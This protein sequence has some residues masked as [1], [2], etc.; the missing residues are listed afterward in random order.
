MATYFKRNTK[1]ELN[2]SISFFEVNIVVRSSHTNKSIKEFSF[3]GTLTVE[4]YTC[5]DTVNKDVLF[6]VVHAVSS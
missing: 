1:N 4:K 3:M 2:N 5:H 6:H